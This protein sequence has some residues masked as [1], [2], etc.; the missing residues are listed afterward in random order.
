[1]LK[2][3]VLIMEK[4]RRITDSEKELLHAIGNH[5]DMSMKE[6]LNYTT[7]KWETTVVR[8]LE[9][10]KEQEILAGPL[11][12]LHYGKL[13]RNPFY[14]AVCI[15]ET[16]QKLE[17]VISYLQVIDSLLWI[18]PVLSYKKALQVGFLS[19]DNAE[20]KSLLQL[21]K[22]NDIITDYTVRFFLSQ[23]DCRES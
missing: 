1:M 18:F 5:P 2:A 14:K 10:L 9:Q 7:Y 15:L 16:Q 11:Y 22:D 4:I 17:T 12:D 13:C 6:L 3:I 19:S 20:M 21:L 23:K 8:K